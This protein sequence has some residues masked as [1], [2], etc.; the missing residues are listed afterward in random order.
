MARDQGSAES[1]SA[2][3]FSLAVFPCTLP[4]VPDTLCGMKLSIIT[5]GGTI[6]SIIAA[7]RTMP[8]P[9]GGR[10][11]Q[12]VLGAAAQRTGFA[13]DVQA[14]LNRDSGDFGPAQWAILLKAV[15][16]AVQ[17]GATR[18]LITHGTDSMA[19]SAAL[20]DAVFG[21][22][23]VAIALLGAFYPLADA[24]SDAV[25]NLEAALALLGNTDSRPGVYVPFY[26]A[27]KSCVRVHA[28]GQLKPMG[29][30]QT[31]FDSFYGAAAGTYT[32]TEG[33]RWCAGSMPVTHEPLPLADDVA[34]ARAAKRV[35][36][37]PCQPLLDLSFLYPIAAKEDV[38][39]ILEPYHSGTAHAAQT[40]EGSV[41]DFIHRFPRSLVVLA[42]FPKRFIEKP[43]ASTHALREAGALVLDD[44]PAHRALTRAALALA[45]GHT[46]HATA[47]F[48]K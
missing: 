37:L 7:D 21:D 45:A 17:Q 23:L 34:L 25:A 13:V 15:D 4:P 31:S 16:A 44:C 27:D 6:G 5:T 19:Y 46:P 38:V 40:G 42:P 11:L 39:V 32:P 20:L 8:T 14:P 36:L 22:K 43:Y 28:A 2:D 1:N 33:L 24:R 18:I 41:L 48:L 3:P 12:L 9:E 35:F 47:R 29:I 10:A 26:D 30:D